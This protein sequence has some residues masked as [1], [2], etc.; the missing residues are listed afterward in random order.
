MRTPKQLLGVSTMALLLPL[1]LQLAVTTPAD[2]A[3][4]QDSCVTEFPQQGLP[5]LI[6]EAH[7]D[8]DSGGVLRTI[9]VRLEQVGKPYPPSPHP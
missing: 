5:L 4:E 3:G 1:A 8:W 2:A 7:L 6:K 9:L